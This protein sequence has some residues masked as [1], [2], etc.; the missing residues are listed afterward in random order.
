MSARRLT[1]IMFL[2]K[3]DGAKSLQEL[4]AV[5]HTMSA[6]N[7]LNDDDDDDQHIGRHCMSW[8]PVNVYKF[9]SK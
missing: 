7:Q 6:D 1:N 4:A 5:L 3:G 2:T 8:L 9:G